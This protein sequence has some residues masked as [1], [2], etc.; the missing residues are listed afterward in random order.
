MASIDQIISQQ[1]ALISSTL[2]SARTTASRIANSTPALTAAGLSY[3]FQQPPLDK[4]PGFGDLL[5]GD[6]SQATIAQIQG[7][8][9]KLIE[10]YFPEL[11]ACFKDTPEKW[12][13]G[14][15]TGATPLGLSQEAFDSAWFQSRD[16]ETRQRTAEVA[17][18]NRQFS[19]AGF[20]L[21]VGAQVAAITKAEQRASDAIGD[22]NRA[23]TIRD[24]ELKWEML[25]FAEEQA[26]TYKVGI[27]RLVSEFYRYFLDVPNHDVDI[28]R[29]K[30]SAYSAM[31]QALSSYYQVELGFENLRL[32]AAESKM[33]GDIDRDRNK[34]S[35]YSG[36][37]ANGAYA[38]AA[39]GFTDVASSAA[40]AQSALIADL[41][42]GNK[43][44]T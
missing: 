3:T 33:G 37:G 4:P 5:P 43:S 7:N 22:V 30:A 9:D 38:E 19:A 24:I 34:I 8:V 36:N 6:T 35:A 2:S 21:P 18:I 41:T 11:N 40:N 16:R 29:T 10:Q 15:I 39:R 1:S 26:M 17:Q 14:I 20:R 25:K 42:T 23:Q 27:M 44:G 31:Q 32:R 28:F 13:C 12:C